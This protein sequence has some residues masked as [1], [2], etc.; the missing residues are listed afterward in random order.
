MSVHK[1][2]RYIFDYPPLPPYSKISRRN[3]QPLA[4]NNWRYLWRYI[5]KCKFYERVL[6]RIAAYFNKEMFSLFK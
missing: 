1:W 2:H 5:L 6:A 3:S 4:D